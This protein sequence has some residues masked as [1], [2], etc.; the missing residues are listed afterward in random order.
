MPKKI[1]D[2]KNWCKI[3]NTQ[4]NIIYLLPLMIQFVNFVNINLKRRS[5][6]R[7]YKPTN[8]LFSGRKNQVA[9]TILFKF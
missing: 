6:S 8:I 7:K 4:H 9:V 5:F 2:T 3:Y 1:N